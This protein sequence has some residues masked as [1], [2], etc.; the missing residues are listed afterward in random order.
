MK[1]DFLVVK[2]QVHRVMGIEAVNKETVE[3]T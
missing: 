2:I 3:T 1:S